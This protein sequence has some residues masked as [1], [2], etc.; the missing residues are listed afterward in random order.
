[1]TKR[2]AIND[3]HALVDRC[4]AHARQVK[5]LTGRIRTLTRQRDQ[6]KARN[7]ELR[8][9]LAEYQRRLAQR[10]VEAA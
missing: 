7:A 4:D 1:M 8:A 2:P 5:T 6:A 10:E 3:L 9:K